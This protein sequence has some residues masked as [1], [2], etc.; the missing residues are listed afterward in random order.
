M[1]NGKNK[2]KNKI[3]HFLTSFSLALY[4]FF[5]GSETHLF[6]FCFSN[7]KHK[8]SSVLL[9]N[10][11]NDF[12][13]G[14]DQL[15]A[16]KTGNLLSLCLSITVSIIYHYSRQKLPEIFVT[17]C[18]LDFQTNIQTLLFVQFAL[19]SNFSGK[20]IILFY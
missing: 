7:D 3:R 17:D 15:A 9:V 10:F 2:F 5:F 13:T 11:L 20:K 14:F 8:P 18:Q 4:I 12:L 1:V 16:I 6:F 19:M